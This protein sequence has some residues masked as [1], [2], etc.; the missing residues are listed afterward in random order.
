MCHTG[1]LPRRNQYGLS[2]EGRWPRTPFLDTF[3]IADHPG[4]DRFVLRHGVTSGPNLA[5]ELMRDEC[6]SFDTFV[7]LDSAV[8]RNLRWQKQEWRC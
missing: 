7:G 8:G 5:V 1:G 4:V 6:H 3:R 2:V